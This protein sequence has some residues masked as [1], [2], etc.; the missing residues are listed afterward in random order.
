MKTALY[1][2]DWSRECYSLALKQ[3]LLEKETELALTNSEL[4]ELEEYQVSKI[5]INFV[6]CFI[7]WDIL[8]KITKTVSSM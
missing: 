7:T 1:V 2:F 8:C 5:H 4:A 6:W 3:L